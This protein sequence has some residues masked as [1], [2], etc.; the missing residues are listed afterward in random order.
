MFCG[1][2]SLSFPIIDNVQYSALYKFFKDLISRFVSIRSRFV[3]E[4]VEL[5]LVLPSDWES[6]ARCFRRIQ[7]C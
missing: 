6:I 4:N 2:S 7:C 1:H 3:I 5:N